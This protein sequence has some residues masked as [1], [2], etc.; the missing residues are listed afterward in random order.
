MRRRKP[1][2][3]KPIHIPMTGLRDT[4]AL[5]MHSSLAALAATGD[6]DSFD[7]L[8]GIMNMVGVAI[9]NDE[10]FTH[11]FRL[12]SG[13]AMALNEVARLVDASV[14]IGEHHLAPVRVAV[15]AIDEI[16]PRLDVARL[17][18][19]EKY[20]VAAVRESRRTTA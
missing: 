17:Y 3:P 4:I 15:T 11:E 1:Y 16:L 14:S 10:R 18:V 8:A 20:A 5:H 9:Q 7:S 13:G 12:V 2:R 6:V 19:S